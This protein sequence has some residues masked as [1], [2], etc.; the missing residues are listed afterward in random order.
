MMH[1]CVMHNWPVSLYLVIFVQIESIFSVVIFVS[2]QESVQDI[3][4]HCLDQWYIF[5]NKQ[6]ICLFGHPKFFSKRELVALKR[7][8]FF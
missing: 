7:A 2:C 6:Y 8:V 4:F 5:R 1:F 3:I